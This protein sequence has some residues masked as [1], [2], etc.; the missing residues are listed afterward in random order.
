MREAGDDTVSLAELIREAN[1]HAR[2]LR[3]FLRKHYSGPSAAYLACKLA[4]A[5]CRRDAAE[6]GVEVDDIDRHTSPE[7]I[8][9]DAADPAESA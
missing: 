1:R 9:L 3:D 2:R 7:T 5:A 6:Q 4:A 8:A